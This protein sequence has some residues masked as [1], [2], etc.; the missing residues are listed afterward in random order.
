MERRVRSCPI[1]HVRQCPMM[2]AHPVYAIV[3]D[4]T[5]SQRFVKNAHL[6]TQDH[7]W[8]PPRVQQRE[9][10]KEESKKHPAIERRRS[11][12]SK[13][14]VAAP[15]NHQ[16]TQQKRMAE[17]QSP[18]TATKGKV[19]EVGRNSHLN[20]GLSKDKTCGIEPRHLTPTPQC[21]SAPHLRNGLQPTAT[22]R[23]QVREGTALDEPVNATRS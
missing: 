23:P 17:M 14:K 2:C 1:G 10:V 15:S 18:P 3:V 9:K 20:G 7:S 11:P 16:A 12:T 19:A 22:H 13:F 21:P 4:S 5:S 8:A 6:P